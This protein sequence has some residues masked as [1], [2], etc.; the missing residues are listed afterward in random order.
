MSRSDEIRPA[1][2]NAPPAARPAHPPLRRRLL[3]FGTFVVAAGLSAALVV[4][5]V[6]LIR[7]RAE[8]EPRPPAAAVPL[9][10]TLALHRLDGYTRRHLHAARVEPVREA[11]LAFEAG[12]TLV[13]VAVDEGE[14]VAAG[15]VVARLDTRL[16]EAKRERLAAA[17]RALD[18]DAELARLALERQGTLERRG[19]TASESLDEARLA[20]PRVEA[21][22]AEA[23]AA[24]ALVD[25]ELDKSV[26]RAPFDAVVGRRLLDE[27]ATV[28][29]GSVVLA[30][31]ED[32]RPRIRVGLPPERAAEL[33]PDGTYRFVTD[34]GRAG[35]GVRGARDDA[36]GAIDEGRTVEARLLSRRADIDT[37]TR[38]VSA[39]FEPVGDDDPAANALFFGE[40][41]ELVLEERVERTVFDVPLD[42]LAEDAEG[43]WSLLVVDERRAPNGGAAPTDDGTDVGREAGDGPA[44]D[45]TTRLRRVAVDVVHTDGARA[46]VDAALED[47]TRVVAGGRHRVVAGERVRAVPRD[48]LAEHVR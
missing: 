41:L 46:F 18:A 13:D 28:A 7:A 45:G 42:A 34:A 16:L 33:S 39:L 20:V 3:G 26:L 37:R 47:G 21:R 14:R 5:G 1:A 35:G 10:E 29:P 40:L 43:L 24:L 19:F 6:G 44:P 48:A 22:I 36:D 8:A 15:A 31:L 11:A 23:D 32:A 30:L 27:G 4:G 9:V 17:R 2:G 25:V 38:T 12:G